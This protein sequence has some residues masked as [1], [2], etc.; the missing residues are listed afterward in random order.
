[1]KERVTINDR[2][3]V[4]IPAA[5]RRAF[6]LKAGEELI[7][8]DTPEG[9]LLRPAV[10]VPIEVYTEERIAEFTRD[11]VAIEELLREIE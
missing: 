7:A 4:T 11:E 6:G 9:I 2:G 8:E 1:M 3:V 10:S 5:L